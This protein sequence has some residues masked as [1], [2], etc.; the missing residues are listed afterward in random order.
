MHSVFFHFSS[1][2]SGKPVIF[3]V[4]GEILQLLRRGSSIGKQ[5]NLILVGD[6]G[7]GKST[8]LQQLNQLLKLVYCHQISC[9]Q[10][11]GKS[12][13]LPSFVCFYLFSF[14][15]TIGKRAEA[16]KTLLMDAITECRYRAPSLL[17]VDDLDTL[18]CIPQDM[19]AANPEQ[20]H[21]AR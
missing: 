3:Q 5:S 6:S 8:V 4:V 19:A 17:L 2:S 13:L 16:V 12:S 7:S 20:N 21:L 1:G 10:L 11:I 9:K 18:C 14:T 15:S